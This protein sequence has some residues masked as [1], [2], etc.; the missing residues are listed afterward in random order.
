MYVQWKRRCR[1]GR[2]ILS[3]YLVE[4]RRRDGKVKHTV[5]RYL[6]QVTQFEGLKRHGIRTY[7]QF[8]A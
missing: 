4:S 3:A 6:A 7:V 5:L 8:H 1:E 2:T